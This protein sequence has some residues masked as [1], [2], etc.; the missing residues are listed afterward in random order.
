MSGVTV[1][2][3]GI[4]RRRRCA[5]ARFAGAARRAVEPVDAVRRRAVFAVVDFAP[6]RRAVDFFAADFFVAD[7]FAAAD[8]LVAFF[9]A[10]FVRGAFRAALFLR[11]ALRAAAFFARLAGAR[12]RADFVPADFRADLRAVLLLRLL[13]LI[14]VSG[15]ASRAECA[16]SVK[17]SLPNRGFT[18]AK[19][20]GVKSRFRFARRSA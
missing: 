16:G 4:V 20:G 11:G 10:V 2:V 19:R 6:P 1:P 8:F 3:D 5:V 14:A 7:F 18:H 15:S 9:A 13:G 12:A 17:T